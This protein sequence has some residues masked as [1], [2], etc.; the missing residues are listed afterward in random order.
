MLQPT[1]Y[2]DKP[3][4]EREPFL[5]NPPAW[6]LEA[7]PMVEAVYEEIGA[8]GRAAT[9]SLVDVMQA[10]QRQAYLDYAHMN[11][12]GNEVVAEAVAEDIVRR[13]GARLRN[14]ARDNSDAPRAAA[15]S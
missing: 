4:H 7:Y 15:G 3:V 11:D 6:W 12:V 8:S 14:A 10:E 5:R 1:G 9:L 2:L 13:F